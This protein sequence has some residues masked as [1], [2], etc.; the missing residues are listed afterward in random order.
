MRFMM[1]D[2]IMVKGLPC[3][4]GSRML[5]NFK[6]PF[7]AMVYE[8]CLAAGLAFEGHV[9]GDELG[10]ARLFDHGGEEKTDSAV[11][12]L[13]EN[14]CDAVLCNDVFGKLRAQAA[15]HGLVYIH[16]AYG[17][18]SRYGL[19]ASVSSMDQIGALCRSVEDAA[20]MLSM[21]SGHDARDGTNLPDASTPPSCGKVIN[22]VEF[23][24]SV[25]PVFYILA[26]AEICNNATRYDGVK[27]GY[28]A[29]AEGLEEVYVRSRSEG[30]GRDLQ[31]ASLVGCMTLSQAHYDGLYDKA[32]RIR[33][34]IQNYCNDLLEEQKFSSISTISTDA[35][36]YEEI[37]QY[38]VP[39]LCGLAAISLPV[40]D[41][42]IVCRRGSENAMFARAK[43]LMNQ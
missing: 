19:V 38:A 31:L 5:E 35:N 8:K 1:Q 12:A 40:E 42:Q 22:S 37:S 4:A 13:L 18:V 39:L 41:G 32:M 23:S 10:I 33:R 21:I 15:N 20:V 27:F 14:R 24:K 36:K 30:M 26:A 28:H 25:A 34:L 9:L 3:T 7:S 16:P 43:E 6:A 11:T 29:E 2:S 17:T